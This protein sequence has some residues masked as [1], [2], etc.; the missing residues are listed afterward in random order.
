MAKRRMRRTSA[1]T[2]NARSTRTLTE[3]FVDQART[4][5]VG[6][7]DVATESAKA[8][9][10]GMQRVGRAMAD[11]AAPAARRS[12]AA[13][14]DAGRA[15]VEGASDASRSMS[16]AMVKAADSTRKATSNAGRAARRATPARKKRRSR[17][18]A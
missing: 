8:A 9:L 3:G 16:D 11:L 6:M 5:S 1:S 18:A 4:A 15:A 13:A 12:M 14:G 10:T 17:R 7:V 2:P